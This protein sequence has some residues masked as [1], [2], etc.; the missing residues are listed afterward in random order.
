MK[1]IIKAKGGDFVKRKPILLLYV[2]ALAAAAF[3][4]YRE[5]DEPDDIFGGKKQVKYTLYLGL[6]DK[7]TNTQTFSIDE[8]HT[9]LLKIVRKYTGGATLHDA[10]YNAKGYWYDEEAKKTYTENTIVCVLLDIEPEAVKSIMDEALK[11]F[12]QS[13]ILLETSEVR[14][15][16]YYGK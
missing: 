4:I 14:D 11:T 15:V 10:L 5:I 8:A 2:I 13:S 7:D 6:N 3:L 9:A 1:L 12:N 16:F